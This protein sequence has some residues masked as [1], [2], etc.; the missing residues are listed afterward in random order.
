MAVNWTALTGLDDA[1]IE[2][3]AK[4]FLGL[5]T[6]KEKLGYLAGNWTITGKGLPMV[7]RYN[8]VPIPF[9][10]CKRLGLPPVGFSDGP[11]GVVMGAS[12]CF[13]VSMAR[14]ATWD[15]D[16]E[17]R[18]GQAI[19]VE[20]RAQG[21]NLFAGVCINLLRHPA[22]GRAQET[23]GE[24]PVLLGAMGSALVR[25]VQSQNVMAC[26][27]HFA[28]N[29]M[30][31][32]RLKVDARV[33]ERTLREVY[34]PHFKQCI[35]AGAASVMGAYNKVNGLHCC[36]Q[37]HLLR[38]ILKDEW[39]FNG[40]VISDFI[41][42]V[43]DGIKAVNAGLDVEMPFKM[44]MRPSYLQHA[45]NKSKITE[46]EVNDAVVRILRQQLR[47]NSPPN[48]EAFS[49]EKIACKEH[50][51]LALEAA[52]KGMVLLKNEGGILPLDFSGIKRVAVIGK[53][54]S[55]SNI[56]DHGSSRVRPPYIRTPLEGIKAKI[57]PSCALVCKGGKS[58]RRA[59][60]AAR[61]ADV[62]IVM[63]GLSWKNEGEFLGT[64][65]G[66]RV[67]LTL[68]RADENIITA[69][70]EANPRM[71]VVIE[72]GS[73]VIMESWKDRVPAIL[74]AW[75]AGMEGGTAIAN[76][77]AGDVNPSGKLPCTFPRSPDQLP[78]FDRNAKKIDY[79][80]Y[81]GYRLFDKN[82]LDPA[83]PFGFGLG[84]SPFTYSK[85]SVDQDVMATDGSIVASVDV[86]NA[87]T[88]PGEEIVQ[89]YIG[90][91]TSTVDRPVKELKGFTRVSLAPG[92]T[93]TASTTIQAADLA[94]YDVNLAIWTVEPADYS[95]L[96]GPS[97]DPR[98]LQ[99][100]A[101]SIT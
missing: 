41:W 69:V 90:Y 57:P 2:T 40:Y 49:K 23:Y 62:A 8:A 24:D 39:Q 76:I 35:D 87:G 88:R 45:L 3:K 28:L 48:A 12:T 22:W 92:E 71:I 86:T 5:L 95:M 72:A 44:H 16:L 79:G 83:F 70:A 96:I 59:A 84:Y 58:P 42:G 37:P 43:R 7:R 82:G 73:A 94:H 27:K 33:D 19:G 66:D 100:I 63:S 32:A 52:R 65:G 93:R 61:D 18:I 51:D 4:E 11:R 98:S 89:F 38:E 99:S 50:V 15:P 60:E 97:S 55:E 91:G 13:P 9:G 31:N 77:L 68:P 47:F 25:G 10:G 36:E 21:A 6:L 78:F 80:Y 46:Q 53:L 64:S 81:H 34:L 20:C 85:A 14:G 67:S 101:F 29:S 75:Y 74:L 30:E 17:Y 26:V 54:A 1:S 56:G